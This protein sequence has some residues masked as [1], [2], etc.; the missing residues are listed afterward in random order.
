MDRLE[1][2]EMVLEHFKNPRN[3]GT[4]EGADAIGQVGNPVCGDMMEISI[5]VKDDRIEDIRFRTFG[6]ASAIA[7]TSMLTEVVKGMRLE[8]AEKVT[9]DDVMKSLGGLPKIKVHCSL[10]AVDG[11]KAALYYYYKKVGV[12]RP[13]LKPKEED[14]DHH[15]D[16]EVN[17]QDSPL[18]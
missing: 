12:D 2:N 3:A 4:L 13:D 6:C 15:H 5:N 14:E 8:D 10:L 1:Y 17:I 11:L 16:V 9:W 7:T 18:V